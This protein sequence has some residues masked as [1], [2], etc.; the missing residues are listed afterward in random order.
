MLLP[1]SNKEKF[2]STNYVQKCLQKTSTLSPRPSSTLE[3]GTSISTSLPIGNLINNS[4]STNK[5]FKLQKVITKNDDAQ[6]AQPSIKIVTISENKDGKNCQTTGQFKEINNNN[7]N[8]GDHNLKSDVIV[9][10]KD[11]II[12]FEINNLMQSYKNV[13]VLHTFLNPYSNTNVHVVTKNFNSSFNS[14]AL[15][16]NGSIN[17]MHVVINNINKV[18]KHDDHIVIVCRYS[19]NNFISHKHQHIILFNFEDCIKVFKTYIDPPPLCKKLN[20]LGLFVSLSILFSENFI[21]GR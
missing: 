11:T 2:D 19:I 3:T 1:T 18:Q 6:L 16:R 12:N 13:D 21:R 20:F 10:L 7:E 14:H 4:S 17:R 9:N 8:K 5:D 15:V